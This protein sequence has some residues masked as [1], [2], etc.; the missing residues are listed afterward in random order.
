MDQ[1]M[2][3]KDY[4]IIFADNGSEDGSVDVVQKQFP[5]VRL[6]K[7]D[8]NYGFS[9]GNNRAAEYAHG[10]YI[11]FLNI[12]TIVHQK[13]LSELVNAAESEKAIKACQS[14][15]LMPWVNEFGS[16]KREGFPQNT[17]YYDISCYGYTAYRIKPFQ[18]NPKRSTFLEGGSFLIERELVKP[19]NYAFDVDLGL[20]CEDLDLALRLN[21]LG[22]KTVTVPTS[23]VYHFN[24][25]AMKAGSDKKS[26]QITVQIIRNRIIA[27]YKN[28]TNLEFILFL[29]LLLIGAPFKV[30]ELGWSLKKQ[31]LY[32]LGAIP[33]TAL[34]LLQA[35]S[36][37]NRFT[38]K[39]KQNLKHRKRCEWWLLKKV[40][41]ST[42]E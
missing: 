10:K 29:P 11:V 37:L 13:W 12:D 17:Y 26:L 32:G 35:L 30:R 3:R 4:E 19:P 2:P 9:E 20:Y 6:I 5:D 25:F 22:Y 41:G 7:F 15:M 33:V 8:R 36:K 40:L 24:S 16:T 18:K 23:V 27:F 39:R 21:I 42:Q 14:N 38:D 1:D 28:M 34:G 31:L